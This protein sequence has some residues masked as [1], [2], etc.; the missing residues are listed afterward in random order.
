[1]SLFTSFV[2]AMFGAANP[3]WL[4]VFYMGIILFAWYVDAVMQGAP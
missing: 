1:M 3:V 2:E 4:I